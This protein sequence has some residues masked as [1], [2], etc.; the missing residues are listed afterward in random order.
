MHDRNRGVP[1]AVILVVLA[2]LMLLVLL[3][4]EWQ[5]AGVD[6]AGRVGPIGAQTCESAWSSNCVSY[7]WSALPVSNAI[8]ASAVLALVGGAFAVGFSLASAGLVFARR[9]VSVPH[10]TGRVVMVGALAT[11]LTFQIV[12]ATDAVTKDGYLQIA[13]VLYLVLCVVAFVCLQ[14]LAKHGRATLVRPPAPVFLPP[15][16]APGFD[17]RLAALATAPATRREGSMTYP[18]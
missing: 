14:R 16:L 18:A 11:A 3:G 6:G 5:Q 7:W 1:S 13:G 12:L 17:P 8:Y 15:A 4:H 2:G 10:R 9:L